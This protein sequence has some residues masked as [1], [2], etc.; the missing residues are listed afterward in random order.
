MPYPLLSVFVAA[1]AL[2]S[3]ANASSDWLGNAI[4]VDLVA[5]NGLAITNQS[6]EYGALTQALVEVYAPRLSPLNGAGALPPPTHNHTK[7][8][9]D[10]VWK[11][12]RGIMSNVSDDSPT[13]I[14]GAGAAGDPASVAPAILLA[15]TVENNASWASAV[16]H[17]LN[18]LLYD[19]P[20]SS[21]GGISQRES[22]VQFWADYMYM[23]PPFLAYYGA[24]EGGENG[25]AL[26][27]EAY[28][29]CKSYRAVLFDEDVSLWE[30]I[31]L[32][33]WK[34]TQH[35]GTGNAWAAYGMMRVLATIKASPWA[36]LEDEQ[37]DLVDWITEIVAG[38]W[39]FQQPN[40]TLFNYIDQPENKTFADSASTALIAAATYRL[41]S[42]TGDLTYIVN[43]ELAYQL[44]VD[45]VDEN[46]WLT[47]AVDPLTFNTPLR[48]GEH[49]PEGQAF[50][51]M[52]KAARDAFYSIRRRSVPVPA[53]HRVHRRKHVLD[54]STF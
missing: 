6:W 34:L 8:I 2:A 19:V 30:H 4:D 50:T 27:L 9:P 46:G 24:L 11:I 13:L 3:F 52:L 26:L 40:G 28:D 14:D 35:W 36:G 12:V 37:R 21:D 5:A 47:N 43:A 17:Q 54:E 44:V 41:A 53:G 22:E 15:N 33:S 23:V 1:T 31:L 29:Q 7:S 20:R 18:H 49:S 45:R 39:A 16:E 51:L 42:F 38:S 25:T 32:G 48:P 10:G